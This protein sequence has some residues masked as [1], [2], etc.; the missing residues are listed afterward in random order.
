VQRAD[1]DPAFFDVTYHGTH[2]CGHKTAAA[3]S[4]QQAAANPDAG[5]LLQSLR[6]TLTVNTA[7]GLMSG[8]Q[9]GWISTAPFSFS[10]AVSGLTLPELFSTPSTPENCF[11]QGVSHSPSQL[12]LSPAGSDSSYMTMDPFEAEKIVSAL[13]AASTEQPAMEEDAFSL[14]ELDFDISIF[15]ADLA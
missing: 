2:T 9:Q 14:D 7:E 8:P 12:E 15:L 1:E 11:G 6:S 4:V 3:A 5:C 10:P 13:V